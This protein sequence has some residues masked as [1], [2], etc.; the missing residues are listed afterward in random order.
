M[1]GVIARQSLLSFALAGFALLQGCVTP[2]T[3]L[4]GWDGYQSQVY[5]HFKGEGSKEQQVAE[6]EKGLQAIR[7]R[8][9]TPPPGYHAHLGMLYSQLG[10]DDQVAQQFNTEEALFPESKIYMDFLLKKQAK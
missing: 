4:Y 9:Q 7:A 3:T 6:L 2:P 8:G 1:K 5:E 10:R